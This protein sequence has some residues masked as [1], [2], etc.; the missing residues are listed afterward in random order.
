MF[1][2]SCHSCK[3]SV[4]VPAITA[5]TGAETTRPHPTYWVACLMPT[6]L[7][8]VRSEVALARSGLRHARWPCTAAQRGGSNP[9]GMGAAMQISLCHHRVGLRERGPRP[10][11]PTRPP[12]PVCAEARGSWK[13]RW[14]RST[15]YGDNQ[16]DCQHEHC[17]NTTL[18]GTHGQ[19]RH[20]G[21]EQRQHGHVSR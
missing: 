4:T 14:H 12:G 1:R 8:H 15:E 11:T 17:I 5:T 16:N 18:V 7:S 10:L 3:F 6:H 21:P 19:V 20:R 2:P 9:L 13:Q